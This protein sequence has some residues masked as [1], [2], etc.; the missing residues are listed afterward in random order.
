M[1]AISSARVVDGTHGCILGNKARSEYIREHIGNLSEE[2]VHS[3]IESKW[4]QNRY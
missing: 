2:L 1:N 3:R 4:E